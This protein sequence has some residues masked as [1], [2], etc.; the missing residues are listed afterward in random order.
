MQSTSALTPIFHDI[1]IYAYA[2]VSS[3]WATVMS[4]VQ[5]K[6]AHIEQDRED[7]RDVHDEAGKR[8]SNDE[9]RRGQKQARAGNEK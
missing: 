4:L 3:S 6:D 9:K 8:S 1:V 7:E 2:P 5:R